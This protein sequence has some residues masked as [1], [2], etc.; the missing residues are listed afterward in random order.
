M[1]MSRIGPVDVDTANGDLATTFA[2]IRQ[3]LGIVPN[4][5]RTM[6]Q[7]P[8]VLHGYLALASALR[9]GRL[10][11]R[12]QAQLAITVAQANACD[13]CLSAHTALA[14]RAGV[15]DDELA[16]SRDGRSSD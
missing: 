15:S 5:M 12:V 14:R 4:M 1:R 3:Q 7:S 2:S 6:A 10:S 8:S 11:A 9:N 13:Y 16:A